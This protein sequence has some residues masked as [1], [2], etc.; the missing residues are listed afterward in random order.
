MLGK[1]HPEASK[2]KM[3]APHRGVPKSPEHNKKN[4]D[5][6]KGKVFT[7]E[8][9][10]NLSRAMK[11][12][13]H[14]M[15][16]NEAGQFVRWDKPQTQKAQKKQE[17]MTT[18][19]E[20]M[21]VSTKRAYYKHMVS[22]NRMPTW[23]GTK[24]V[25]YPGDILLYQQVI[26]ENKPDF[27]VESGTYKGGSALFFAHVCELMGHGQVITVDIKDH[28]PPRHPRITHIIGRA[29]DSATLDQV[30]HMIDGGTVMVILDSN[31]HRKHVKRELTRYGDMVTPGQFMVVEDTN[32]SE[33]GKKDGPD[34]AVAWFLKRTKKFKREPIEEQFVFT[35]NP[36]GWLRRV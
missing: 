14:L 30:R 4:S 5:A 2:D 35:L 7:Q 3:G 24:V 26:Y 9:R 12:I 16:R 20:L 27:I 1:K 29:T 32:Y 8:H 19:G 15:I 11:K 13:N 21:E 25:K 23:M 18:G 31:H 17:T 10:E 34:E 36:G 28:D 22:G 33:I 6:H